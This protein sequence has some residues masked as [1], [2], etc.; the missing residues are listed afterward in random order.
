[1]GSWAGDLQVSINTH[2]Y[3]FN[4]RLH[5]SVRLAHREKEGEGAT[6]KAY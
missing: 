4:I 1:M 5:E 2:L 3:P 6:T